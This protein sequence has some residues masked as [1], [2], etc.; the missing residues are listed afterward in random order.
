VQN[1]VVNNGNLAKNVGVRT[2]IEKMSGSGMIYRELFNSSWT[3]QAP[4]TGWKIYDYG[5]QSPPIWDN[6]DWY[7]YTSYGGCPRVYY[8]PYENQNEWLVSPS[9]NCAFDTNIF[10]NIGY[11]YYYKSAV[12]TGL[13]YIEGSTDGGATW[14]HIIYTL[15]TVTGSYSGAK[16][17]DISSWA[18]GQPDV[19]IRFRLVQPMYPSPGYAYWYFDDFMIYAPPTYTTCYDQT[20]NVNLDPGE[21]TNVLLPNWYYPTCG[22]GNYKV[23]ASV[24]P[25]TGDEVPANDIKVLTMPIGPTDCAM[26][27]VTNPLPQIGPI[28]F[29]PAVT[30]QQLTNWKNLKAPVTFSVYEQPFVVHKRLN[31]LKVRRFNI[32]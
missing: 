29:I 23:T 14:P 28:D 27:A 9:I 11:M 8:S 18:A 22:V 21:V 5:S 6:N 24:G 16:S 15:G 30:V 12:S 2:L 3:S 1:R 31:T 26:V 32:I 7:R 19:Q 13:A 25:V 20:V 4:P 10:L 17:Y